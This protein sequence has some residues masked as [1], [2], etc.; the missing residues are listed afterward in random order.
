LHSRFTQGLRASQAD[1]LTVFIEYNALHLVDCCN[2][3]HFSRYRAS[4]SPTI[5]VKQKPPLC[6]CIPTVRGQSIQTD[7]ISRAAARAATNEAAAVGMADSAAEVVTTGVTATDG[8]TATTTPVTV[9]FTPA[10]TRLVL[11]LATKV[12]AVVP[13]DRAD[14]WVEMVV[15]ALLL[16]DATAN[17]TFTPPCNRWRPEPAAV[18]MLVMVTELWFTDSVVAIVLVNALWAAG[19]NVAKVKP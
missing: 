14:S 7:Y 10:V 6:I 19:V 13:D 4:S 16:G 2:E 17:A 15:A 3:F 12:V 11:R 9:V 18:V 5:D 1:F 8:A